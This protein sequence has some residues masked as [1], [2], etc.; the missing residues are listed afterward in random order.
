LEKN[1]DTKFKD[2]IEGNKIILHDTNDP[3]PKVLKNVE[4]VKP[5]GKKHYE[6]IRTRNGGYLFN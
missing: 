4:I 2:R 6:I 5:D 1:Q 3:G